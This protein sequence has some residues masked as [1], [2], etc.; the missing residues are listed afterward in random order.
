MSK[1]HEE[2]V[3][4]LKKEHE[5]LSLLM[6][7]PNVFQDKTKYKN[8]QSE[9][10]KCVHELKHHELEWEAYYLKLLELDE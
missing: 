5:R 9:F 2:Q 6:S 4:L 7:D 1:K 8:L 10:E 3:T